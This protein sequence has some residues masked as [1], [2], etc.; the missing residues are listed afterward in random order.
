MG[1]NVLS[2]YRFTRSTILLGM[3]WLF[4]VYGFADLP[5]AAAQAHSAKH[6]AYPLRVSANGRYLVDQKGAPFLITGDSPQSIMTLL[7]L[8]QAAHYFSVR[9]KQG[10]NTAGWIDAICA[11]PDC[12]LSKDA[13]TVNGMRPFTGYVA[14]GRDYEH[15]DMSKPNEDYFKQLDAVVALAAKHGFLVFLN[16]CAANGWLPTLRNNGIAAAYDY[17]KYLGQRY[18]KYPNVAWLSGVDFSTWKDLRDDALVRAVARGIKAEAPHQLQTLELWATASSL[19]NRPWARVLSLNGTYT[20]SSAYMQIEHSY[21]QNPVM[22]TFLMETHYEDECVGE[23]RD[24]GTAPVLRRQEYWSMLSGGK[25]VWYGNF[26]FW[27][28]NP[29]WESHFNTIG[30]AQIGIWKSFFTSL[31]WQE[32]V[33]DGAHKVVVSGLGAYGTFQT[34][35]SKSE[36]STAAVTPD[37]KVVVVYMPTARSI[38]VN[39]AEIKAPASAKWF[40]PT[41]GS[42]S[43]AAAGRVVNKG[44]HTFTPPAHSHSGDG[45]WVLLLDASSAR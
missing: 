2:G 7:T 24:C 44:E 41:D 4:I 42:Y 25:G 29:A 5:G 45:D 23:P 35:V 17:G 28:F 36:F 11:G 18:R 27:T 12:A 34:P 21:N 39:M 30:V 31:P 10:F 3:L 16:P 33:P 14:G 1:H 13:S 9:E 38:T 6:A 40:D 26:Y 19:D 32:L 8:K 22:P 15:Y 37:G 43:E 20:Y